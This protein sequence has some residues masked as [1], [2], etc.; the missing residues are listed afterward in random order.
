[1]YVFGVAGICCV[2]RTLRES[3]QD[4]GSG[5]GLAAAGERRKRYSLP[6]KID[7]R[8]QAHGAAPDAC[9]REILVEED[10]IAQRRVG[11]SFVEWIQGDRTGYFSEFFHK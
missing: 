3:R 4:R 7:K 8:G 10:G 6:E 1:M 9:P 2:E 5:L 11:G